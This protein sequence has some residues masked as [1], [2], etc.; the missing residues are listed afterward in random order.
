MSNKLVVIAGLVVFLALL[1]F[2]IWYTLASGGDLSPPDL[3]LPDDGSHCV[4][5]KATMAAYH[6]DLLNRWRDAVV[7]EGK[8]QY[9]SKTYGTQFEMSLTKTCMGC[10]VN[11]ETFC[12]RC[13]SYANVKLLALPGQSEATSSTQGG[14]RCWNCHLAEKEQGKETE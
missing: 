7:R 12:D 8:R 9:T 11:R 3:E 14:I 6:M 10:H 2:P 1:T 4:E 13:H 5:E